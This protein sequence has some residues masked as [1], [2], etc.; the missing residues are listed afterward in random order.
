MEALIVFNWCR[1]DTKPNLE[2]AD[3]TVMSAKASGIQRYTASAVWCLG[4]TYHLAT[5]TPPTSSF[6]KLSSFLT[7]FLLGRLSHNG[8][9]ASVDMILWKVRVL[10]YELTR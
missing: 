1:C 10:Y 6:K 4:M 3:H 8:S 5:M 2:I 7:T 9:A